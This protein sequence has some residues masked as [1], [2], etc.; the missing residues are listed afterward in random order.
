VQPFSFNP[1]SS[2]TYFFRAIP[3]CL[4][5]PFQLL[6]LLPFNS[7]F[8]WPETVSCHVTLKSLQWSSAD[9]W[10]YCPLFLC[11]KLPILKTKLKNSSKQKHFHVI[12]IK[13]SGKLAFPWVSPKDS[14]DHWWQLIRCYSSFIHRITELLRLEKNPT[15]TWTYYPKSNNTLLNDTRSLQSLAYYLLLSTKQE[16]SSPFS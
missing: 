13:L 9:L 1:S 2:T 3:D 11:V 14:K 5:F 15:A 10:K 6:S 12:S 8:T 4:C 16:N 7:N